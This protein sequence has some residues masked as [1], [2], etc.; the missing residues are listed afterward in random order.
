MTA[1]SLIDLDDSI[2][3]SQK[4]CPQDVQLTPG[5]KNKKGEWHSF[6]TPQ[7][8]KFLDLLNTGTVIPVTAREIDSYR[9][10]NLQFSSYAI[11]TFGAVILQP[12]GTVEPHWHA[13]IEEQS[14]SF[15][16]NVEECLHDLSLVAEDSRIDAKVYIISDDGMPL[17]VNVK[18]NRKNIDDLKK[19]A[20]HIRTRLPESWR[21]HQNS[22][23]LAVLPPYLGKENAVEYYLEKLAPEHS[24]V[25][26]LGDSFSDLGFMG[27]C[28]FA[29]TPTR[30]Q[31][32]NHLKTLYHP[33]TVRSGLTSKGQ[34]HEIDNSLVA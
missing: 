3:Q 19:L 12:D 21:L 26:G 10:V 27:L 9:R 30:G 4:K 18:H 25:L 14:R 31:V 23:N 33:V 20:A 8:V 17:Y 5:A 13:F 7:Q 1:I 28:D 16:G 6:L 32:F 11:T 2:F 34:M 22:N 24:F 15:A 29:I